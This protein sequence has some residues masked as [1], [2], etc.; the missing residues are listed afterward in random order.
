VRV[1]GVE[2]RLDGVERAGADVAEDDAERAEDQREP[3]RTALP[4]GGI[5]PADR[6]ILTVR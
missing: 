5:V 2:D 4:I 6:R 3:G 1:G